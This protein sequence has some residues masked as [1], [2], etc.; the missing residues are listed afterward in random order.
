M[1]HTPVFE[2]RENINAQIGNTAPQKIENPGKIF[3]IGNF[4]LM[5]EVNKGLHVID[6]S[7]KTS[8]V[9][10]AFITIPGSLDVYILGNRLYA[11]SYNDLVVLDI[12][13]INHARLIERVND[14]FYS[15]GTMPFITDN[16]GNIAIEYIE[17]SETI[18]ADCSHDSRFN[19]FIDAGFGGIRPFSESADFTVVNNSLGGGNKN[20]VAVAESSVAGKAGSM[21]R[22]GSHSDVLYAVNNYELISFKPGETLTKMHT[23]PLAFGIETIFPHKDYLFV[24]GQNGMYILDAAQPLTPKLISTFAHANSCDPVAVDGNYAY[25]TLRSGNECS[26]FTNQLD[27]VDITDIRNPKLHKT[28]PMYNPHGLGIAG[29]LLF[30]CDGSEGLKIYNKEN[31]SRINENLLQHYKNIH[32]FDVIPLQD[33]LLMVGDQGLYQYDYSDLNNIRLLSILVGK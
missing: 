15:N 27:V 16:E 14:V 19:F 30:I 20:I 8:P 17:S 1:I 22:F 13:D 25:V 26:G 4:I 12:S 21:S 11:D 23:E 9:T 28:Y 6:N 3:A 2:S 18:K 24:G 5:N 10:V 33:V 7:D 29:H 32:A 31:P